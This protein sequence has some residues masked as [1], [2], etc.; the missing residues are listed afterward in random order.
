MRST[1]EPLRR[2]LRG[3]P[4]ALSECGD[5]LAWNSLPADAEPGSAAIV[6]MNRSFGF[7]VSRPTP[8]RVELPRDVQLRLWQLARFPDTTTYYYL[9]CRAAGRT[10]RS[11]VDWF[12]DPH[13]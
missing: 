2:T 1:D 9:E 4:M 7:R 13:R 10:W 12:V 11:E 5:G 8:G 6:L 3:A